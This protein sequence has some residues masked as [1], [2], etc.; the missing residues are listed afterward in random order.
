MTFLA[1]NRSLSKSIK[2][3]WPE[4]L[5]QAFFSPALTYADAVSDCPQALGKFLH[6]APAEIAKCLIEKIQLENTD[7]EATETYDLSFANDYLNLSLY[8]KVADSWQERFQVVSCKKMEKTDKFL[9][10]LPP[11]TTLAPQ[12]DYFRLSAVAILHFL[13]TRCAGLE[14][15]FKIGQKIIVDFGSEFSLKI[16]YAAVFNE[17]NAH[18]VLSFS[19]VQ[20]VIAAELTG[21]EATCLWLAPSSMEKT[22]FV[23]L[24]RQKIKNNAS[25]IQLRC[26][27]RGWLS[28]WQEFSEIAWQDWSEQELAALSFY[29]STARMGDSLQPTTARF[30]ESDNLL[31]LLPSLKMRLSRLNFAKEDKAVYFSEHNKLVKRAFFLPTFFQNAVYGGYIREYIDTL[32]AF[33]NE[34]MLLLGDPVIRLQIEENNISDNLFQSLMAAEIGLSDAMAN[35][36]PW[37]RMVK[38][39]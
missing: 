37:C 5:E 3:M 4:F 14:S 27:S 2:A 12:D 29:M 28:G 8:G 21:I 1:I 18:R 30:A 33:L 23:K 35:W 24:Y 15:A 22:E 20:S 31:W 32:S 19:E 34:L 26:L 6:L 13:F 10:M 38:I 7:L 39:D 9:I 11:F 36:Q 17:L 16:L 25:Q